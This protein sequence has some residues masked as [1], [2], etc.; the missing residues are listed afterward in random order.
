MKSLF[1]IELLSCIK[2]QNLGRQAETFVSFVSLSA[3]I[4]VILATFKDRVSRPSHFM[5]FGLKKPT[6][7]SSSQ[8][9]SGTLVLLM[10]LTC[11]NCNVMFVFEF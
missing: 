2:K 8:P 7:L 3:R 5:G 9:T 4:F 1:E 11:I 6:Q 10:K